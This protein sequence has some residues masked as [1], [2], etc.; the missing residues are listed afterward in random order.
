MKLSPGD[1]T[2]GARKMA[3]QDGLLEALDMI[4]STQIQFFK[5]DQVARLMVCKGILLNRLD[6]L[7]FL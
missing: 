7:F 3:P 2:Y 4:E 6:K 5:K 1:S